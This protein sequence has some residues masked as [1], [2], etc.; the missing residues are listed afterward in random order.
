MIKITI[1]TVISLFAVVAADGILTM[2]L[3]HMRI[4]R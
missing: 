2:P 4:T 1:L 3:A